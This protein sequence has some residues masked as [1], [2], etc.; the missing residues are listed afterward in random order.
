[1]A[2]KA[3]G[4][5]YREG[6]SLA[7]LTRLFPDDAAAG[8]WFVAQRWPDGV[9]CPLCGGTDR[10]KER[11]NRKPSP[12][13]CGDCRQYFSVKTGSLM[14]NSPLGCQ[15]WAIAIYLLTTNLKGVSSMKLHR[16]LKVTQKTAWFLAHR[17]RDNF[18]GQHSSFAGPVEV[19]ETFVGGKARNMHAHKREQVIK[20]RGSVGKT[21]VVGAKDRQTNRVSAAV[22]EN[23][24]QPT[25]Q[26]FVAENVEP[27]AKVYTD[28]HGGY[29][30][31]PNHETVRHSV[32]EY[33]NGQGFRSFSLSPPCLE[34][35]AFQGGLC[36][37]CLTRSNLCESPRQSRGFTCDN[38]PYFD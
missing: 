35:G 32:K 28:D 2:H 10:V 5:H 1:M 24:D 22:V 38:Y 26:G 7:E 34:V 37:Y 36:Y 25:L 14:H 19:D 16:D 30:G 23:V 12:Y 13:H 17:I 15:T 27:G 8:R 21:A 18:Q 9:S 4:K 31:L 29:A 20:G 3:P 33:V 11:K 6:L